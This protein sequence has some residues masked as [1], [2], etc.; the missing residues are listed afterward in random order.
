MHRYMHLTMVV[1]ATVEYMTLIVM[2]SIQQFLIA[3]AIQ[4]VHGFCVGKCNGI[5][6]AEIG[7]PGAGTSTGA[8]IGISLAVVVVFSVLAFLIVAI[9]K[10]AFFCTRLTGSLPKDGSYRIA[11][12][13]PPELDTST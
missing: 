13:Q 11:E 3:L 5:Y 12:Y 4:C 9:Y 6:I 1:I 8:I 7:T 10:R 2:L